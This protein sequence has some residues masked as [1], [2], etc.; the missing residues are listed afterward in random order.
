[1]LTYFWSHSRSWGQWGTLF[2]FVGVWKSLCLDCR[3]FRVYR[4]KMVRHSLA[5]LVSTETT[6]TRNP[7]PSKTY[8]FQQWACHQL[9][10]WPCLLILHHP[11]CIVDRDSR[12]IE[13]FSA[14][15]YG[16]PCMSDTS[17]DLTRKFSILASLHWEPSPGKI[18]FNWWSD[19]YILPQRRCWLPVCLCD[20]SSMTAWAFKRYCQRQ[21]NSL[22]KS[23]HSWDIC[24][25]WRRFFVTIILGYQS[26]PV[27]YTIVDGPNC[28]NE[29]QSKY[30]CFFCN[31][32][33][34]HQI[35]SS[36]L[37]VT[38]NLFFS[39]LFKFLRSVYYIVA[40]L[41]SYSLVFV[42]SV[43]YHIC[44]SCWVYV[45]CIRRTT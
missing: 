8:A 2:S 29:L 39:R 11:V 22:G 36:I 7:Q 35:E 31:I 15:Q 5:F 43:Y 38:L 34:A 27:P 44:R 9:E 17:V 23:L 10:E 32:C 6:L 13:I 3:I 41:G 12:V 19:I 18:Y 40:W 14:F 21:H 1:M 42:S 4:K 26:A 45:Y 30:S 33:N 20:V 25:Y 28:V 37:N 24:C 16:F